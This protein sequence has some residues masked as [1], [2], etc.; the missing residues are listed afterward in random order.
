M[1]N[2][3]L[4]RP[5]IVQG[6]LK[7]TVSKEACDFKA[8]ISSG[9]Y[10]V[11]A[12]P[13]S[14]EIQLE[15]NNDYA[16][17]HMLT[18]DICRMA[19]AAF[20][21][22]ENIRAIEKLPKSYGWTAIKC[23]YAAYFS[24]HS[25]MRCFG[26]LCG[27]L[28]RG[29]IRILNDYCKSLGISEALKVESGFFSGHY[30]SVNR[31]F[32]LKKLKNTHEDTWSTF[33]TF[34]KSISMD[35][36]TVSGV[37]SKKQVLSS[38]IDDLIQNLKDGGRFINGNFLSQYRN[39]INYRQEHCSWYPYGKESI[40][41]DKIISLT[42]KWKNRT[43]PFTGE[44]KESKNTYAFFYFCTEIV[45]FCYKMINLILENSYT[46]NTLYYRWPNK[47]LNLTSII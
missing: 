14:K 41:S 47:Y 11:R 24:A 1:D 38:K 26:Y 33:I 16:F 18:F 29:H 19:T 27:Q 22:M 46:T 30:S 4:L 3:D 23:Y 12:V 15:I 35:V 10:I 17:V 13:S 9:K 2:I 7:T 5:L 21:T 37:T 42:K 45:N 25:I 6:L 20:E 43:I 36:L 39:S 34:L 31:Y 8:W 40:R 32:T 44:W 28:E